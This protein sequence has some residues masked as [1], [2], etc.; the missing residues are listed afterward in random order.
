MFYVYKWYNEDTN[1]IFYIGKGCRD[2][3]KVTYRRN[4]E[5][6]EYIDNHNVNKKI[7]KYFENEKEALQYEHELILKYKKLG[8]CSCNLDNGGTG[9][10]N[11]I[12]TPEMREYKSKFNPMYNKFSKEKM[13]KS[14]SK[15]VIYENK[16]TTTREIANNLG[17]HIQT[18]QNWAKRG[19]D[20]NGNPCYYK[21]ETKPQ[22]RKITCSKGVYLNDLFFPSL[23]AACDY[24]NIKDTSPLCKAL[25]NNKKYHG[26]TCRYANQQPSETNSDKSSFDGSE[27]NE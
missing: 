5:F 26:Y 17:M 10:V 27:T 21:N 25:K 20:T 22:E 14:K 15:I 11:F 9:G 7:I 13:A 16:E 12:W 2:R 19:Y 3:Y 1:E 8:Q 24:L 4:K 6:L 23:R 18:I